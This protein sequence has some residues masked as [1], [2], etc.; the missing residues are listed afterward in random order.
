LKKVFFDSDIILDALLRRSP[1]N[2]AA[3]TLMELAHK[4]H[5]KAVTSSA[6]FINVHYFVNKLAPATKMESLRRLRS[7][8]SIISVDEKIIDMALESSFKD[9][10]DAVQYY[11]AEKEGCNYIITRNFKDY[12]NSRISVLNADQFIQMLGNAK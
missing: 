7:V 12:K 11:S 2:T 6:V 4:A 5:F 9:F 3:L 10:E 8:V 1:F